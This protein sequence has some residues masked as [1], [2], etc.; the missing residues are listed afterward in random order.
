M[1]LQLKRSNVLE[2]GAAKEPTASQLDYGELAVNYNND[3]PAIFLKTS[4]NQVIRISG[5][6]N[7]A[8]DGQVE[9][10]SGTTTPINPEVGNLWFNSDEA[11][12]YIYYVDG[13]TTQWVDASPDSY[14][15][16]AIP[17][18]SNTANQPGTLDDR[19]NNKNQDATFAG[20]VGIGTS[21]PL[22]PLAFGKSVY[23][24]QNSENFYRIKFKDFGGIS[25]DVGIGQPDESSLAFNIQGGETASYRWLAGVAGERMRLDGSG[26]LGVGTSNPNERLVV[27]GNASVTGALQIT[28]NTSA[29]AAGAFLFRPADN[30]LALGTN[31]AER[32]RLDASGTVSFTGNKFI[33][34]PSGDVECLRNTTNSADR[35]HTWKSD[36]GGNDLSKIYFLADGSADFAG[37]VELQTLVSKDKVICRADGGGGDALFI[38]QS[39]D[40]ASTYFS[41]ARNGDTK[42]GGDASLGSTTENISLNADGSATFAGTLSQNA[43]LNDVNTAGNVYYANG[44]VGIITNSD[45]LWRGYTTGNSTATSI[46]QPNGDASF[47][48]N[49]LFANATVRAEISNTHGALG[50]YNGSGTK[51][52]AINGGDGSAVFD[53]IV[54]ASNISTF[55][56]NLI[57]ATNA[58]ATL[59]D[60]KTAIVNALGDL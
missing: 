60:L 23:G 59:A 6:G 31:S 10:P 29:P 15:A 20:N 7:I 25:N 27:S 32:M 52:V 42:I 56:S 37:N 22:A 1:K 36:V 50:I 35:L 46:I 33:I 41:V 18:V 3:D 12:L 57:A 2:T 4:S 26:N 24:D 16:S 44:G 28:S 21:T 49:V 30:T 51:K 13:D 8:D 39:S 17:D 34:Q 9:I 5:V 11:R 43:S 58:A 47:A 53:G 55:K 19:Y 54:T 38:G 40:A 48:G 45:P 14:E